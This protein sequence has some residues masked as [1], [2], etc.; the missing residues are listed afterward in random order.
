MN[1]LQKNN[2]YPVI[3]CLFFL[4]LMQKKESPQSKKTVIVLGMH[5]CGTSMIAGVLNKLGINMGDKLLGKSP[6]N[7]LG[8]FEDEDFLDLN[9]RILKAARGSWLNPPSEKEI[10]EQKE[11]FQAEI[12][13]L[14]SK[15]NTGIWGWKD[16]RTSLTI[17]LYIDYLENPYFIVCHR[18]AE[19]VAASLQ[20]RDPDFINI[21][22]GI[23]LRNLYEER[24]NNFFSEH[25]GLP[26]LDLYY[27]E[28]INAPRKWVKEIINFLEIVVSNKDFQR[29][30]KFILPNEEVHK[31]SDVIYNVTEI[32]DKISVNKEMI[33]FNAAYIILCIIF[34]SSLRD[35]K[36][37]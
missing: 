35:I 30:V 22:S 37:N 10:L 24:I 2:L 13:T 15:V 1:S 9:E 4:C 31:I 7:P 5:R 23:N 11:Q 21:E 25:P 32:T 36:E 28:V 34:L 29:A 14:T 19:D 16:P 3:I 18:K 12:M 27:E 20:K 8:H 33:Y 26:R 6:S 17:D